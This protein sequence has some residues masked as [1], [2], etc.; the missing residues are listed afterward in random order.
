MIPERGEQEGEGAE[1]SSVDRDFILS[2]PMVAPYSVP[3]RWSVGGLQGWHGNMGRY[4]QLEVGMLAW[5]HG[6]VPCHRLQSEVDV[7]DTVTRGEKLALEPNHPRSGPAQHHQLAIG[8][9]K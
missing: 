5:F 9:S 2:G 6:A 8:L 3:P 1:V 4:S 7:P